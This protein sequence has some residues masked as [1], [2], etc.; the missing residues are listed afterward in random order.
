MN[1]VEAA[2]WE[3]GRGDRRY[4]RGRCEG[5][6][7][8]R[9]VAQGRRTCAWSREIEGGQRRMS[10]RAAAW[11]L[12][13]TIG[14]GTEAVELRCWLLRA[15]CLSLLWAVVGVR[16]SEMYHRRRPRR[17]GSGSSGTG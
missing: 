17:T 3:R 6:C 13:S 7:G 12:M 4:E 11:R 1:A 15:A 9:A 8:R 14:G 16:E 10:A 5:S 2:L